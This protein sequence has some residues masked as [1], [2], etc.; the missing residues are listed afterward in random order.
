MHASDS[1]AP[2]SLFSQP[3]SHIAMQ[4]SPQQ[5]AQQAQQQQQVAA[6]AGGQ[7]LP[8]NMAQ[9]LAQLEQ[10]AQA[11]YSSPNGDERRQ[12]E[13]ML[14]HF[15]TNAE[16]IAQ[17]RLILDHSAN[18]FALLLAGSSLEKLLTL[19]FHTFTGAQTLEIVRLQRT[20]LRTLL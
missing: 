2:I 18:P 12:A 5:H 8:P 15:S 19:F 3:P 14:A 16:C 1:L 9:Q 11:Q 13:A 20:A 6:A 17:S 10:L 4:G 7:Q